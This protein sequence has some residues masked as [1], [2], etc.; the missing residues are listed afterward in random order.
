MVLNFSLLSS[1]LSQLADSGHETFLHISQEKE[2]EM[3]NFIK[4]EPVEI[5]NVNPLLP[6]EEF[7]NNINISLTSVGGKEASLL[8]DPESF[9]MYSIE[10]YNDFLLSTAQITPVK[11]STPMKSLNFSPSQ[12]LN[13]PVVKSSTSALTST[14][15]RSVH[16]PL[17]KFTMIHLVFSRHQKCQDLLVQSERQHPLK[18]FCK[19]FM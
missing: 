3:L 18:L 1:N 17:L 6:N 12:F 2:H 9:N 19:T 7:N 13:S 15:K 4:Q 5:L 11:G 10:D 8:Y 16:T 14:P